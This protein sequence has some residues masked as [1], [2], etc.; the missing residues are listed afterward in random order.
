MVYGSHHRRPHGMAHLIGMRAA[1]MFR[2]L[3]ARHRLQRV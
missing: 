2:K 3:A 1:V